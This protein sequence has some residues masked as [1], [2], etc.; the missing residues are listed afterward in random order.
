VGKIRIKSVVRDRVNE[1]LNQG[2]VFHVYFNTVI[3]TP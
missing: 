1:A 2:A 3:T